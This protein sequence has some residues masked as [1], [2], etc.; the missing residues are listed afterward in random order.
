MRRAA[1]LVAALTLTACTPAQAIHL[2][3]GNP[4]A[5]GSP[6]LE[7]EAVRVSACESEH[8]PWAVSPTNDH[9]LFQLHAPIWRAKFTEVTGQPWHE[10]YS[11]WWNAVF[12]HWLQRQSGWTPWACRSVL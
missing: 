1:A 3:F 5:G 9:G 12:A 7:Q 10:V 6:A 4:D 11:P 8:K 2:T